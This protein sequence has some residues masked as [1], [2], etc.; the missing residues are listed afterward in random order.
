MNSEPLIVVA[1]FRAAP[2]RVADLRRRL[3]LLIEPSRAEPTCRRYE[4]FD[5]IDDPAVLFFDEEWESR[6]AHDAHLQT[7]HVRL[8]V[9]D[10]DDLIETPIVEYRGVRR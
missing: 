8:L 7:P 4:L 9:A 1:A 10:L 3:E 2:G 6:H 5:S